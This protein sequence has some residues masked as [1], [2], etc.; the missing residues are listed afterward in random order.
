MSRGKTYADALKFEN[1][2]KTPGKT[3]G[4]TAANRLQM[5]KVAAQTRDHGNYKSKRYTAPWDEA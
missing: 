5:Q 3:P 4:R 1:P 2:G